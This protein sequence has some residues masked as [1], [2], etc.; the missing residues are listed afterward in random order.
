[1]RVRVEEERAR[2]LRARRRCQREDRE[3]LRRCAR[4]GAEGQ[5]VKALAIVCA[6]TAVA[7]AQPDRTD[8]PEPAVKKKPGAKKDT[9]KTNGARRSSDDPIAKYF[10]ELEAMKLIDTE[11]GNID[12]LRRELASA[13]VLLKDGAFVNAAV[14]LYAIVKSPRYTAFTDLVEF[15]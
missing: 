12:T 11:S 4:A 8:K 1:H 13:E 9:P 6:L 10:S 3:A 5:E 15:Q 7:S 2:Q 14:E